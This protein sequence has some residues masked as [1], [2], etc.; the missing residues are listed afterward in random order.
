MIGFLRGKITLKDGPYIFID[1]CGVGYKV[2]VSNELQ[3]RLSNNLE[4]LIYTYTHIREDAMELFGFLQY[5][6]LKLFEMLISVS[7]VG[8][9]TAVNIFSQAKTDQIIHAIRS[10]NVDF[11]TSVPRLGRKNAQKIII[12]LKSKFGENQDIDIN[13]WDTDS[14]SEVISALKSLGFSSP[15]IQKA[16]KSINNKDISTEEKIKL[17]FKFLGK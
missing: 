1:V 8:P 10:S 4:Y 7:G 16:L 3:S 17:A 14:N 15:E 9:K 11:F 12:E 13:D 5:E 6:D 2:L